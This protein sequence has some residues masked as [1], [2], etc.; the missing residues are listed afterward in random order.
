MAETNAAS[1]SPHATKRRVQAAALVT[2]ASRGIG[3]AIALRLASLG[4]SVA[5]CIR[6]KAALAA[7]SSELERSGGRVYARPAGVTRP[8]RITRHAPRTDAAVYRIPSPI[9]KQ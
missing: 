6:D 9:T 8:G 2:G 7:T 5:I 4:A 1:P 3:R